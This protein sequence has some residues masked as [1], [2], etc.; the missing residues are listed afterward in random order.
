MT[1]KDSYIRRFRKYGVDP[2]S[3]K[4]QNKKAAEQRYAEIVALLDFSGKSIL[5]VGCGVGDLRGFIDSKTKNF[6][7]RGI[8]L[9]EEFIRTAR[10]KHPERSFNVGNY[11][12]NPLKE[13]FDIV[14]ANGCLNSNVADNYGFRKKAIRV[15][16]DH[17]KDKVIFNM[18]GGFAPRKTAKTSNVFFADATTIQSFCKLFTPSVVLINH[19]GRREFTVLMTR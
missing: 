10:E 15:M 6:S 18:A 16:F 3:L 17:A 4:W 13:K 5:D 11:F 7:Y 1:S 8:E 12:L 9:V 2:R 19:P 14:V